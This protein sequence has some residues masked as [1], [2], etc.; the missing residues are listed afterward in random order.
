MV[1]IVLPNHYTE[2]HNIHPNIWLSKEDAKQQ[3]QLR[4]IQVY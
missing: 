4:V 1:I 3:T 2:Q